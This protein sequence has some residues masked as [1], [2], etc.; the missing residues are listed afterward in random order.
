[1]AVIENTV[2]INRTPDDVFDYLVDL[3][4]ELEWNPDVERMERITDGPIGVGTRYR[5]KWRRSSVIVCE[6]TR[7]DRPHAWTYVNGGPVAVTLD[8]SL[9]P[10]E[11]G[12]TR[13]RSRF[14]AH[15]KGLFRLVFPMFLRIM[16]RT[17]RENMIN[18]RAALEGR[19]ATQRPSRASS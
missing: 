18:A 2:D 15:P 17:E 8:I 14:E 19:P 11:G 3:S 6:C 10:R 1:M 4:N 7:Y 13:L 5:A 16:R 12:G 9:S